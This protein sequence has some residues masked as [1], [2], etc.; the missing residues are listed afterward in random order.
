MRNHILIVPWSVRTH[1]NLQ[2]EGQHHVRLGQD[3]AFVSNVQER[4]VDRWAFQLLLEVR[5][6]FGHRQTLQ[7]RHEQVDGRMQFLKV[8]SLHVGGQEPRESPLLK[9]QTWLRCQKTSPNVRTSQELCCDSCLRLT[10]TEHK[11]NMSSTKINLKY[12]N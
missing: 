1:T 8:Q 5:T 2:I 4:I 9:Y 3:V 11:E 6:S 12:T 10:T 7:V